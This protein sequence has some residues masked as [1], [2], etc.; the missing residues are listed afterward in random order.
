MFDLATEQV[1]PGDRC[2]SVLVGRL[3]VPDAPPG[4]RLV[5]VRDDALVD[6]SQLAPTTS[7]L[8]D[9]DAPAEAVR[10]HRGERLR[11]LAEA[12]SR[13]WLLAPCDWQTIK[14]A[15]VTFA[16]SLLERVIEER[17]LGDSAA[18]QRLRTS[19]TVAL[20]GSLAGVRPGT[21][22]ADEAR[23]ILERDGL[24]SQYLEV[25]IGADAEIFTKAQPLS[26]IG[27]G[28][29]IGLHPRS[30]W[31]TTEPEIVLAIS[32]RGDVVGATLGNDFTLR[33]FEGR[34]ALLL[35]RAK[36]YDSSCAIG[37][38]VRLFDETFSLDTV[39]KAVV[40]TS[41][42]GT[43]GFETEGT[44]SMQE[45]SRDPAE[46]VTATIG[47][48][49]RYPDG[50]ML[51]LGT[52]FV[53]TVDRRGTGHGFAHEVGDVVRISCPA[54]GM[55]VNRIVSFERAPRWHFGSRALMQSLAA[56]GLVR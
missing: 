25:G 39:R 52:M 11:P 19:L 2:D 23:R 46:L 38:F 30:R 41:V 27:C 28:A 48:G 37:P 44:S 22:A 14:A 34:S 21:A 12:L 1:L 53:P 35:A 6:L 32:A 4:P 43:D 54:L 50:L 16:T 51:F 26:A 3:W 47:D 55:L 49:H 18:A 15:G 31:S 56:R 33:D 7:D 9:L 42:S 20:G 40:H 8:F 24:W 5:A 13:R 29:D 36:D 10:G 17:A 45:I